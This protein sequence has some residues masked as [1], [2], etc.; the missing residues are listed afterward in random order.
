MAAALA[1]A[2]L[3]LSGCSSTPAPPVESLKDLGG[4]RKSA[5]V[6]YDGLTLT[7]LAPATAASGAA[8]DVTVRFDNATDHAIDLGNALVGVRGFAAA[9][10]ASTP[11]AFEPGLDAT[12]PP[13]VTVA[14]AGSKSVALEFTAPPQGSYRMRGVFG[15]PTR[16]KGNATPMLTL[17]VR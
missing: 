16:V 17:T 6:A 1:T 14:A 8:V 15:S 5:S 4:G 10:I 12:S 2:G 7:L 9:G 13:T 11:A 3:L